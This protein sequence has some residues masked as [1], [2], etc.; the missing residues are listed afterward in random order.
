M[1]GDKKKRKILEFD[2][3]EEN[4]E[5]KMEKFFA[6]IKSTRE[7]RQQMVVAGQ[8]K[9]IAAGDKPQSAAAWNPT[10]TPEDFMEGPPSPP[11]AVAVPG[12]STEEEKQES[13]DKNGEEGLDLNLSL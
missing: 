10:F 7:V 12:P 6:L 5:E 11:T 9:E 13:G 2:C 4:E 1:D 3:Q 8:N